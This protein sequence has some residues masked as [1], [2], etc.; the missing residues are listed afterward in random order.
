MQTKDLNKISCIF[1]MLVELLPDGMQLCSVIIV[2]ELN[3]LTI[4][5][6]EIPHKNVSISMEDKDSAAYHKKQLMSIKQTWT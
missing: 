5:S 1:S 3:F 4:W 6:P 2:A